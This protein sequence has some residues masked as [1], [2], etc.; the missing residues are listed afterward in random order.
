MDEDLFRQAKVY[1]AGHDTSVSALV[2]NLIIARLAEGD[3]YDRLWAEG[4]EF[5][6]RSPMRIG[7]RM[8]T[9]E[10]AHER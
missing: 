3:E 10:E 9:R 5:M 6:D 4:L 1:A 8:P 7:D 2:T